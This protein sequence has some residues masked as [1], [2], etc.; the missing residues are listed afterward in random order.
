MQLDFE[1]QKFAK[2]RV[3]EDT[4]TRVLTGIAEAAAR[5]KKLGLAVAEVEV[6]PP[7][8]VDWPEGGT[9]LRYTARISLR[10][11]KPKSPEKS[12]KCFRH[13]FGLLKKRATSK[14]WEV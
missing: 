1:M 7:E 14:G 11:T 2:I 10:Q 9:R 13:A 12:L 5:N 4:L 3:A 8:V 6:R